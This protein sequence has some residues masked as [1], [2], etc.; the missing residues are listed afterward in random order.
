[1]DHNAL[2]DLSVELGRRLMESGAE[3][4]RVE[5]SLRRL[6]SAY[7]E[8]DAQVF[9]IPNCFWIGLS[10]QGEAP[11]TRLCR[12]PP[13]GI[14]LDTLELCNAACR[15]LCREKPPLED[16]LRQVAAIDADRPRYAAPLILAGHFM[17]GAFFTPFFGGG[18]VDA[19]CGGLCGLAVGLTA[20]LFRRMLANDFFRTL[21][22]SALATFLAFALARFGIARDPDSVTIG[23]LMLLVPGTALVTAMREVV[24]GDIVSGVTRF[25]EVILT[26]AAIA[27]GAGLGMV[28]GRML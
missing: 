4:H 3:I 11:I 15:R 16:A 21:L 24:A 17:V 10:P 27:L 1:M 6:M 18:A 25:A 13:H 22:S 23:A 2:I 5:D 20:R 9:A 14:D 12:I 19:L 7:G 26:A 8:D 28:F